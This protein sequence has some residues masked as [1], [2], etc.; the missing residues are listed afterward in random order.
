M[1]DQYVEQT[2]IVSYPSYAIPKYEVISPPVQNRKAVPKSAPARHITNKSRPPT[3]IVRERPSTTTAVKKQVKAQRKTGSKS[4]P[5][6]RTVSTPVSRA[7]L[8]REKIQ[9]NYK[10]PDL[11][12]QRNIRLCKQPEIIKQRCVSADCS[13]AKP[14]GGFK[15]TRPQ[16]LQYIKSSSGII[17]ED[18]FVD[19]FPD[20]KSDSES[21]D[22]EFR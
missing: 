7:L 20:V 19:L 8:A 14:R 22:E 3:T 21:E 9:F 15:L 10:P 16:Y 1:T 13:K 5:P 6:T 12:D 2:E 4:A 11:D 18:Y 17:E